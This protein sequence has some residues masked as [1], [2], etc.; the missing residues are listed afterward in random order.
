M[1]ETTS[2]RAPI[3]LMLAILALSLPLVAGTAWADPGDPGGTFF[4]DDLDT[5][6][7]SIEAVAAAGVTLG[8]DTAGT[9][10]CPSRP[11]TRA[12][13][14]TFLARALGL[15]DST[16]DHFTDDT[17]N[18]HEPNIN[19]IADAGISLGCGGTNYCPTDNVTRAQMAT[20]LTRAIPY[21]PITPV[22]RPQT[23]VGTQ[24]TLFELTANC[25]DV[26]NCP[27]QITVAA[28]TPFFVLEGWNLENWSIS[29]D[30][31]RQAFQDPSTRTEF[32]M[33]GG[34][35]MR[36]RETFDVD[37]NDIARKRF[38]FQFPDTLTGTHQLEAS[39]YQLGDMQF[40]VVVELTVGS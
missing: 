14:A 22:P 16:T 12:Q 7:P 3:R 11:V 39:W 38:S 6:E 34:D 20:F 28:G 27:A 26:L 17:G 23:T 24:L 2:Q 19:K 32:R 8:C 35:P 18:T 33:N 4:D 5:H 31:D 1:G 10:Y 9:V 37:E 40:R 13:M 21:T 36:T 25:T 30:L 15:P 29:S